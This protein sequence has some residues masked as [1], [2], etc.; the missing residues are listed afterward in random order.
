MF[1][2][3]S[4]KALVKALYEEYS[5]R[6]LV[7]IDDGFD[8]IPSKYSGFLIGTLSEALKHSAIIITTY[9]PETIIR[10]PQDESAKDFIEK[11]VTT[12]IATYQLEELTRYA[13]HGINHR[14]ELISAERLDDETR[15]MV[16]NEF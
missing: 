3:K 9:R 6:P 16:Y 13:K 4:S 7:L 15:N 14:L 1:I 10:N 12:Y 11:Y 5:V 2:L 8:G